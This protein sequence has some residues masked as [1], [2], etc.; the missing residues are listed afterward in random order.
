MAKIIIGI[1]GMR[2]KPDAALL[3][4]W[5]A[6]SI[7]EGLRRNG[8]PRIKFKFELVY[9]ANLVHSDPLDPDMNDP[10]NPL[11]LEFPYL[12]ALDKIRKAPSK[13]RKKVLDLIEKETDKI[14]LNPD[15]TLNFESITDKFIH[16]FF[17]DLDIYFC[18]NCDDE[19][20]A[21]EKAQ[22][23]IL[24]QTAK[25]IS[26]YKRRK[27]LIIGHSMG[28][29][30]AFD[31]LTCWVPTLKIDSLVTAGS[32]LGLPP[33]MKKL[34]IEKHQK[35]ASAPTTPENIKKH[36]YNLSDLTDKVALNYSLSDDY[37][38]NSLGV[39]PVDK[40]VINDY[41][42]NGKRNPHKSYGYLRTPEMAEIIYQFL[43]EDKSPF[44]MWIMKKLDRIKQK[45]Q[46][47]AGQNSDIQ[48]TRE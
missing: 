12:P 3:K 17:R 1:H 31:A 38:P 4:K 24:N 28:S 7:Q 37:L 27:T 10:K 36:W 22:E 6:Q 47:A 45:F 35:N 42:F 30:I 41:E 21:F 43:T 44:E 25:I 13:V 46:S 19:E 33:I 16:K 40:I 9:W 23:V 20:H 5:W 14:F 29:I 34:L 15:G 48:K 26:K 18:K 11:F 32:P 39:A 2:N 8:Y